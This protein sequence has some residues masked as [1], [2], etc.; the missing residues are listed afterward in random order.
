MAK[1][2]TN[3]NLAQ[4]DAEIGTLKLREQQLLEQQRTANETLQLAR[5]QREQQILD[6]DDNVDTLARTAADI[7]TAEHRLRGVNDACVIVAEKIRQL[8]TKKADEIRWAERRRISARMS[9]SA[10]AMQTTYEAFKPA[11]EGLINSMTDETAIFECLQLMEHLKQQCGQIIELQ[12][13]VITAELQRY[14]M[15]LLNA[16]VVNPIGIAPLAVEPQ[17]L[18]V[19]GRAVAGSMSSA[20]AEYPPRDQSPHSLWPQGTP[21]VYKDPPTREQIL[22][23]NREALTKNFPGIYG[24]T[25]NRTAEQIFADEQ[26]RMTQPTK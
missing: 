14:A 4:I 12:V 17:V 5:T 6:G 7:S 8:A 23:Q 13:K 10:F 2:Q 1:K 22:A 11:L 26:A 24:E 15:Q 18:P 20:R 3:D 16:D 25:D 19:S 9:A 21:P